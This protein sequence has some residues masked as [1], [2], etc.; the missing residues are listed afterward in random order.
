M[1]VLRYL[2]R[3]GVRR[4]LLGGSRPWLVV[5]GVALAARLLRRL[6]HDDPRVVFSEELRPGE[7]L[8]IANDRDAMMEA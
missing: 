8:V 7:A 6:T 4:G 3:N 5:G 1:S 2:V